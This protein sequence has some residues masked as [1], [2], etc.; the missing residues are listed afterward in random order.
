MKNFVKNAGKVMV[1]VIVLWLLTMST[2]AVNMKD[3][4]RHNLKARRQMQAQEQKKDYHE[5]KE[6]IVDIL[7]RA[8]PRLSGRAKILIAELLLAVKEDMTSFDDGSHDDMDGDMIDSDDSDTMN[9]DSNDDDM[10][11]D[12]MNDDDSSDSD[13][14]SDNDASDDMD[15]GDDTTGGDMN[16]AEVIRVSEKEITVGEYTY[17]IWYDQVS[18]NN[19]DAWIKKKDANGN[20]VWKHMVAASPAD[21]K[22]AFVTYADGYIWAAYTVDGGSNSDQYITKKH[23]EQG[24]FDNVVFAGYGR[25]KGAA[26]VSIVVKMNPETGKIVKGTFVMSR[27]NPGNINAVEKTNSFA[28]KNISLEGE[29]VVVY[30]HSRY[31]PPAAGSNNANFV[32]H[33]NANADTKTGW[34][35]QVELR[36]DKDFREI[37]K[38]DIIQ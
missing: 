14:S 36:F 33:P 13:D 19:Q 18:K 23:I 29:D 12:D 2:F 11:D 22:W 32:Q 7:E 3:I 30:G 28:V 15:N 20:N 25:A 4:Y 9:D 8:I 34:Y 6:H 27:T 10:N 38:S 1:S 31:L 5:Y 37:K 16:D 35:R 21:E 17:A 26:K 24:A